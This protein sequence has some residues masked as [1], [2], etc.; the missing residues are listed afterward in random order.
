MRGVIHH[1]GYL[2]LY[3]GLTPAII[4]SAASW[5]GFFI[6]YEEMK[7]QMLIRKQ[8][9]IMMS[10]NHYSSMPSSNLREGYDVTK[11][12]HA[13]EEIDFN[14]NNATIIKTNAS[15][16]TIRQNNTQ[17]ASETMEQQQ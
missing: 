1:E 4:G 14:T 17:S 9:N 5:G 3:R 11:D 8:A 7:K 6:L 15:K 12:M 2:G 10:S 16:N 13:D